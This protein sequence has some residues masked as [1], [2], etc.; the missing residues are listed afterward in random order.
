[1][2]LVKVDEAVK[3]AS[4]PAIVPKRALAPVPWYRPDVRRLRRRV[5]RL[6]EIRAHEARQHRAWQLQDVLNNVR[7]PELVQYGMPH[8]CRG[9][10]PI[11]TPN[12]VHVADGPAASYLVKMLPGQSISMYQ[13]HSAVIA[14]WLGGVRARITRDSPGYLRI[15]ILK[16]D[17]LLETVELPALAMTG[18]EDLVFLG[19]DELG[20]IYRIRAVDLVHLAVQ[21]AT[22]SGKSIF[23]YCL[24]TQLLTMPP[25]EVLI[26]ISDVSGLLPRPFVGTVHEPWQVS[27]TGDPVRHIDLLE[28]LVSEMDH[29]IARLPDRKDQVT[30]NSD[31]PLITVILEEYPG[32]L[33]ALDDG[34]RAGGNVE[35]CRRLV[36]RLV[37][38]G[39]KAGIRVAILCNRAEAAVM[40]AFT[41]EQC[42]VRLSFRVSGGDSIEML[43]PGF[44][45]EAEAHAAAPP[46]VAL[47][48]GPGVPIARIKSPYIDQGEGAY[49]AYW[50]AVVKLAAR[51]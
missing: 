31:T 15:D 1:M 28:A 9:P 18:P 32:L 2:T 49:A 45:V 44:R 11:Y 50:D 7:D 51:S 13:E 19:V 37:S 27:G 29:R 10:R 3:Q 39:R 23:V 5:A 41:R 8:T 12:V 25:G 16:S 33:R 24:I 35:R 47:L 4:V 36:G 30:L 20:N 48:S 14:E 38:E 43:H 40:E 6:Q 46:G 34:K 22:G 26:A 21:G 42:V 17:P